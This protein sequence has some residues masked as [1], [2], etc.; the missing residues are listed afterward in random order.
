MDIRIEGLWKSYG[1][2]AVLADFS[3]TFS[4]GIT[5]L[6]AP[7]GR[8]KTT[9]LRLLLGLETPDSGSISGLEGLRLSAVFQ[10][11][12]LLDFAPALGN[13]RFAAGE[14]FDE[15]RGLAL[16]EELGLG[17]CGQKPAGDFSGGMRRRLSLAR[18]L[19]VPFDFL[20]L[21]EPFAGLDEE[22]RRRAAD[23]IR[24][25]SQGKIVVLVSHEAEDASLLQGTILRL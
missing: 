1:S 6:M 13:L 20:L 25:Q 18:A 14:T 4:Q 5:C 23:V 3:C 11:D 19:C 10:E 7:S 9:L 17:D 22:N 8:G 2:Q 21:D 12:R 15:A 24:R 16:L